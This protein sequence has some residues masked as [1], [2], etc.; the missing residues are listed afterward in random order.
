MYLQTVTHSVQP[1]ETCARRALQVRALIFSFEIS[2]K[3]L[4]F[5]FNT[6]ITFFKLFF[7]ISSLNFVHIYAL[8]VARSTSIDAY[9]N[10]CIDYRPHKLDK[11][12]VCKNF[13]YILMI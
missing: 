12:S 11:Y 10:V 6:K 2:T 1:Q 5:V 4:K 8:H 7:F 13:M 3:L 9:K